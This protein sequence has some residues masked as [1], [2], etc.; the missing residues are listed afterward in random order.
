MLIAVRRQNMEMPVTEVDMLDHV[1]LGSGQVR[2]HVH[3]MRAH[4]SWHSH[5]ITQ[6]EHTYCMYLA[7]ASALHSCMQILGMTP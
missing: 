6:Q 7:V 5:S 2:V 1:S 3:Q 4:K